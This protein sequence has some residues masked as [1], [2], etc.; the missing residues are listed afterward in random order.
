MKFAS[1][2]SDKCAGFWFVS[3]H[4]NCGVAFNRHLLAQNSTAASE[5]I[6]NYYS[7]TSSSQI[8]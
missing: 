5:N 6:Q 1:Y 7:A 2:P 8:A 4:P 3:L